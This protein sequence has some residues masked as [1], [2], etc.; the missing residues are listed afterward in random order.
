MTVTEQHS[1]RVDRP[2][3]RQPRDLAGLARAAALDI[4]LGGESDDTARVIAGLR[5]LIPLGQLAKPLADLL[6]ADSDLARVE[7]PS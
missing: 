4:E 3:I 2:S 5:R 7:V 6:E 1:V